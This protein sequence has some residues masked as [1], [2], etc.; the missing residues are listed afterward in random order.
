MLASRLVHA[1]DRIFRHSDALATLS[2]LMGVS[3]H[4]SGR[5]VSYL[6]VQSINRHGFRGKG[7]VPTIRSKHRR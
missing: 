5:Y 6:L 1:E 2:S 3:N 7:M 4:V